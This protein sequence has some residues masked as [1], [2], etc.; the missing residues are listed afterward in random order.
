MLFDGAVG[1]VCGFIGGDGASYGNTAGIKAS[2]NQLINRIFLKND[3][4]SA[5][6]YYAKTA[7]C[8][9]G[10]FVI[11]GLNASLKINSRGSAVITFKNIIMQRMVVY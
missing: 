4:K 6:A 3:V 11:D 2:G 1:G 9:G 7:H 5:Y 8:E 10:K